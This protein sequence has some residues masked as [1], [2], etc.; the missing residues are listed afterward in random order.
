MVARSLKCNI[1]QMEANVA[2][3][4]IYMDEKYY[5]MALEFYKNALLHAQDTKQLPIICEAN[6]LVACT[7]FE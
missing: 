3:G 1:A 6:Y 5:E 7:Y 4:T 2:F